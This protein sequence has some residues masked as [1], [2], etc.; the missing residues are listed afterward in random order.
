LAKI[1]QQS[2]I[3]IAIASS[4]IAAMLLHAG[5]TARS[6]LKLPLNLIHCDASVGKSNEGTGQVK[7]LQECVLM[8]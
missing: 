6:T 2:K 1:R 3:A 4:G 7:I 5:R 8:V